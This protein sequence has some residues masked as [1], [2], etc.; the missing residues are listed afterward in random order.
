MVRSKTTY[1]GGKRTKIVHEDSGSEISTSAPKDNEGDGLLFSPTDLVGAALGSCILTT[2]SIVAGR[3]QIEVSGASC[4]V[5]KEMQNSPRRIKS[6]PAIVHLPKNLSQ[7][8]R[9][10]LER[11][12]RACPVHASLHPDIEADISFV[13]DI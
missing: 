9:G 13:Y 3:R 8:E 7:E 6:L 5:T 12:G 4:E 2:I 11:A 1:L 10:I